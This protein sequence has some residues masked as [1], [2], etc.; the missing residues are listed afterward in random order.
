MTKD[1]RERALFLRSFL[2]HPRRVGAVLPT[3]RRAVRD[4]LDLADVR[5]ARH[6]V[7]FGAGTGVYTRELLDRLRPDAR[8]LAFEVDTD[9]AEL[10]E[11]RFPDP[12]LQV[13]ADSAAEIETYLEGAHAD[14]IVSG[15]PFTSLPAQ[16][17]RSV[18][19]RS[20]QALIPGGTMLVLQYSPM[21]EK[22]LR[23]VF[24]SVRRRISPFNVPPAFLF[25]C[26]TA[27]PQDPGQAAQGERGV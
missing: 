4:M 10:L 6:V 14:I 22:E 15:L 20:R 21:L 5:V 9:L 8:M 12:R 17:R 19:E 23:H 24:F 1:T 27:A 11:R 16:L 18:L 7:E 26:E 3:S 13:V 25:A 2:A